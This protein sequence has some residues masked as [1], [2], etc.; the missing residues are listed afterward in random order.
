MF[1]IPEKQRLV[2]LVSLALVSGFLVTSLASYYVSK[3]AMHDSIVKQALPLTSD[4]I[5]SEIQRDLLR[6]IFISS[7]MA[8]DT[9]LR[10]W[11][12]RGEKDVE[13][14]VRYL[15]EVKNKYNTF[16]S[17]FVSERTR[18]YYHPTGI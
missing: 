11:A 9:F 7:M 18:N 4:N 16:T 12:L 3:S 10:D 8:Q 14:I 6:P 13:A 1:K 17:F 5:Y 15:T 2:L